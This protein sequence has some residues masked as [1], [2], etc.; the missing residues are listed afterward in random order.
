MQSKK[1]KN[2]PLN[3]K[4]VF[5]ASNRLAVSLK[6]PTIKDL[7]AALG[8]S[9]S[10]TTL[11]KYLNQWKIELLK[12]ASTGKTESLPGSEKLQMASNDKSALEQ[13]FYA[14]FSEKKTLSAELIKS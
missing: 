10:E 2:S 7:R 8:G 11:H 13:V 9:G 4:V 3:K 1:R 14:Q 12:M 5:G 6:M